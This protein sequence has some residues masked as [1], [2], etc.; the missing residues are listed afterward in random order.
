MLIMLVYADFLGKKKRE[1][2]RVLKNL[3][4]ST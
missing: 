3:P 4:E 2:E 1:R